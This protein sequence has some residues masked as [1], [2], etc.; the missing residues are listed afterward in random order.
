VQYVPSYDLAMIPASLGDANRALDWL[1]HA[2][3]E[4][5]TLLGWM[6]LDPA[7]DSL[8]GNAR[9]VDILTR[10]DL[11]AVPSEPA[12]AEATSSPLTTG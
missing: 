2:A 3:A 1:D 10:L 4:R 7:F 8:H 6:G 11:R 5:S 12:P 9:F